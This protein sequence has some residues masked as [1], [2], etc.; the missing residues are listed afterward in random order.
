M[1]NNVFFNPVWQNTLFGNT[2]QKYAISAVVFVFLITGFRLFQGVVLW[3]LRKIARKTKTELDD[4][5]IK[6]VE[7][8]RPPLYTLVAFWIAFTFLEVSTFAEGVVTALAIMVIVYQV[9]RALHVFTDYALDRYARRGGADHGSVTAVKT[10]GR[11]IKGILWVIGALVVLQNIGINVTSLVAGLGIGGVAIALAAQNILGDL[12]SSFAIV[13]DKPFAQGDFIIVGEHMG[14]VEKVGIKTTRL[15]AL[16][17]EEIV[18]SNTEL[19]NSRIQN[20]RKMK[21]R[22]VQFSLGVTY[23][24]PKKKLSKIPGIIEEIVKKSKRRRFDRANFKEF[25]DSALLYEVVYYLKSGDYNEYMDNQQTINLEVVAAFE[26]EGI[27]MAY[28]T[29]TVYLKSSDHHTKKEVN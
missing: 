4:V 11:A 9:I 18:I 17:G 13:F 14:V 3:R 16:Q 1:I 12:F 7:D 10:L 24:T 29:R 8:V 23:D 21:E 2:L 22:R 26:K 20:F 27:E 5:I 6:M 28:P 25:G 19:T 15:R